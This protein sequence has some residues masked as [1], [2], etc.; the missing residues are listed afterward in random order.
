[1]ERIAEKQQILLKIKIYDQ[2]SHH[3]HILLQCTLVILVKIQIIWRALVYCQKE[4]W[5]FLTVILVF[6]LWWNIN[7]HEYFRLMYILYL[8][9]HQGKLLVINSTLK[10]LKKVLN[11]AWGELQAH[12]ARWACWL[13]R[14][15][16]RRESWSLVHHC[17]LEL[18]KR[19]RAVSVRLWSLVLFTS[20]LCLKLFLNIQGSYVLKSSTANSCLFLIF[21]SGSFS[22][23]DLFIPPQGLKALQLWTCSLSNVLYEVKF[24]SHYVGTGCDLWGLHVLQGW[25]FVLF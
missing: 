4:T 18:H 6:L 7:S 16:S 17:L 14:L 19:L 24:F 8:L 20:I 21:T 11:V 25:C 3:R 15:F 2:S 22:K 5:T 1:M 12:R 23:H 13:M 10:S 9:C